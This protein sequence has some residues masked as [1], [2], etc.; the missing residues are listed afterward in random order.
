[1]AEIK[2]ISVGGVTYDIKDEKA[3]TIAENPMLPVTGILEA[4][5]GTDV[6]S[7]ATSHR[8][9]YYTSNGVFKA[10][11]ISN[12]TDFHTTWDAYDYNDVH[13][14][15][16]DVYASRGGAFSNALYLMGGSLYRIQ[17]GAMVQV[18]QGSAGEGGE[19]GED[20]SIVKSGTSY[21]F[22]NG[23]AVGQN[24][25]LN[26]TLATGANVGEG[27]VVGKSTFIGEAAEIHGGVK[28]GTK[29]DGHGGVYINSDKEV[30]TIQE[31]DTFIGKNVKIE[32]NATISV[33]MQTDDTGNPEQ[34]SY[35][36]G[37]NTDIGQNATLGGGIGIDYNGESY[38]IDMFYVPDKTAYIGKE[39]TIRPNVF[40]GDNAKI[41][42]QVEIGKQVYIEEGFSVDEGAITTTGG[43]LNLTG[44]GLQ[45]T[46]GGSV[47]IGDLSEIGEGVFIENGVTINKDVIIGKNSPNDN[48]NC[49]IIDTNKPD[50]RT[51]LEL[52]T[53]EIKLGTGALRSGDVTI[54][55]DNGYVNIGGDDG[56]VNI[57]TG[58][59]AGKNVQIDS[60]VRI[61]AGVGIGN[62]AQ[63]GR[64]SITQSSYTGD[65]KINAVGSSESTEI[66]LGKGI[67][68]GTNTFIDAGVDRGLY[69]KC[70]QQDIQFG[71]DVG[72]QKPFFYVSDSSFSI[73]TSKLSKIEFIN[74]EAPNL[75]IGSGYLTWGTK[76]SSSYTSLELGTG[77]IKLGPCAFQSDSI[78][79]GDYEK[80]GSVIIGTNVKIAS[81]FEVGNL[82]SNLR[83]ITIGN[84]D[85]SLYSQINIGDGSL[86]IGTSCLSWESKDGNLFIGNGVTIGGE[87]GAVTIGTNVKIG[88]TVLEGRSVATFKDQDNTLTFGTRILKVQDPASKGYSLEIED[89]GFVKITDTDSSK[90]V[91]I[92]LNNQT[93]GAVS[94]E[95]ISV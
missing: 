43:I 24:A 26:G 47:N 93:I 90:Y 78:Y 56:N 49:I 70:N 71:T 3:R 79:I 12:D 60:D 44:K 55:G 39:S 6:T 80:G 19:L 54:G 73:G 63:I 92:P 13:Y 20:V 57:G 22:G 46:I 75:T 74:E 62:D 41:G 42:E 53:G 51:V 31:G 33:V 65:I 38:S 29:A 69:L 59:L 48:S 83:R 40:V 94:D 81:Y 14:P 15:A 23:A 88:A 21:V 36:L 8:G 68:I 82:T 27:A 32:D 1:M 64:I 50:S 66:T 45:S 9:I 4:Q 89:E 2:K 95:T 30:S 7:K 76:F 5:G 10:K 85:S 11:S 34:G 86:N 37:N 25:Q 28:I 72:L 52:G 91:R 84:K 58:F 61:G 67:H 18:V 16:S 17:A 35:I 77:F 87:G